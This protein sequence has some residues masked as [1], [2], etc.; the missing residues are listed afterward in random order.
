MHKEQLDWNKWFNERAE[1]HMKLWEKIIGP[2]KEI[3]EV[4]RIQDCIEYEV[5]DKPVVVPR[6]ST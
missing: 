3:V 5:V 1:A 6:E 4:G 2:A